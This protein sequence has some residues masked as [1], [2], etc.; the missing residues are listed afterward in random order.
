MDEQCENTCQEEPRNIPTM[1]G[2]RVQLR[3]RIPEQPVLVGMHQAKI[4]Q[5]ENGFILEIGCKTFVSQDWNE[6]SKGLAEYW[7]DPRKAE[8]K[9][10]KK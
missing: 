5:V 4:K 1:A 6:I 3:D 9:F 8:K 2:G 7:E 10:S